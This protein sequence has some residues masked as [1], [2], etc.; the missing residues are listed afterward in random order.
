MTRA[1]R[2][3]AFSAFLLL[4]RSPLAL[5]QKTNDVLGRSDV[6]GVPVKG[7][8]PHQARQRVARVLAPKLNFPLVLTDGVKR[9]TR[10]RR[11]WGVRINAQAMIAHAKAGQQH[12]PLQFA[13]DRHLLRAALRHVTSKFSAAAQDAKIAERSGAIKIIPGHSARSLNIE[14][15]AER[16]AALLESHGAARFLPVVLDKKPAKITAAAFKGITGRLGQF[17]TTFHPGSQKR[18]HN[19][20]VA[21]SVVNGKIVAPGKTFSLNETLGERTHQHGYLT[22]PV[23]VNKKLTPG[24]GGGV[25]QV[26]GTLFN[27][28]LLAD[29]PIVEYGTHARPVAYMPIGRD[30]TL[31]WQHIDL[32]FK[33]NTPAPLYIEYTVTGR[34][35]IATLYG[36]RV[37]GRRVTLSVKSKKLGARRITAALYRVTRKN[38]K[39]V[40][41]EKI[42]RSNYDW[43]PENSD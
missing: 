33:N 41:K 21:A 29:L 25:S 19:I 18:T 11:D 22:A 5:A 23:Y 20:R 6:A 15:S 30:A 8:T 31:A 12:I 40:K 3:A 42:G 27:A 35:V 32:K 43:K 7:L 34:R 14:K 36:A 28:A 1:Y 39:V 37:A 10:K 26:A 4:L 13:V 16:I 9:I 2:L 24:I 17:T 38:G